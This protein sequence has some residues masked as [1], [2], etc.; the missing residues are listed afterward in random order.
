MSHFHSLA[1]LCIKSVT[2]FLC[3]K[4]QLMAWNLKFSN[5]NFYRQFQNSLATDE[6]NSKENFNQDFQIWY[7]LMIETFLW[8]TFTRCLVNQFCI[9]LQALEV[10]SA[11]IF[12]CELYLFSLFQSSEGDV[13]Q[14]FEVI[15]KIRVPYYIGIGKRSTSPR[16]CILILNGRSPKTVLNYSIF[17][18]QITIKDENIANISNDLEITKDK[19]VKAE[20]EVC[21][22]LY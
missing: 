2:A 21:C 12:L 4:M 19:F 6:Q 22:R 14:V 9:K 1:R 20:R 16:L 15:Y 5:T 11:V 10:A 7:I 13:V 3:Q 8:Q 18:L 17:I